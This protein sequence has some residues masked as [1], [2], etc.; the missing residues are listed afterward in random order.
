M[1]NILQPHLK[2]PSFCQFGWEF[3][4]KISKSPSLTSSHHKSM[5]PHC[6]INGIT[7]IDLPSMLPP[8]YITNN[9]SNTMYRNG[10]TQDTRHQSISNTFFVCY[11]FSVL[12][13]KR[14]YYF[15]MSFIYHHFYSQS[16]AKEENKQ[17]INFDKYL[18]FANT[19]SAKKNNG[20]S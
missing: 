3:Y 17:H 9:E 14:Y 16:K 15:L 4:F 12:K 10:K 2:K 18:S 11:I 5:S 20:N 8:T 6:Y 19:T 13:K 1:F 7:F